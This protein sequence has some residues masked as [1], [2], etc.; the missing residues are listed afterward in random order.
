MEV[1]N[2]A[3]KVALIAKNAAKAEIFAQAKAKPEAKA[4]AVKK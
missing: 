3:L 1:R 2:S 4:A